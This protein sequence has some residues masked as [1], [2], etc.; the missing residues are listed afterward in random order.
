MKP[1]REVLVERGWTS[2]GP[3]NGMETWSIEFGGELWEVLLTDG[4]NRAR[5]SVW[6]H[7]GA[8]CF[9]ELYGVYPDDAVAFA[10]LMARHIG[11]GR[12]TVGVLLGVM[13]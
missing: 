9:E 1:W 11:P 5:M 13:V 8:E 10:V 12:V 4:V 2:Y 7:G 3:I 6:R